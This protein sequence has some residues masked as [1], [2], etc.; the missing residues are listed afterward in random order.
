MSETDLARKAAAGD[1]D[2]FGELVQRHAAVARRLARAAL[3]DPD[4]ADDA[5]QDAFLLA[6]RNLAS[7]DSERPFAP[8]LMRIVLNA[9]ADLRRRRKVRRVE[10]L[11]DNVPGRG[12]PEAETDKVL[13]NQRFKEALATLPE[14]QRVAVVM[15]DAEGFEHSEIAA[16]LGVPVGTVRS[17][18]FHARRALRKV[19]GA[20]HEG[21]P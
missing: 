17:D 21:S 11:M 6:W 12:S 14:R 3:Q 20:F 8:W 19:L 18:V 4:D 2:A 5:V 13:F 16:V 1:G 9:A 7:F 15:F 10:P